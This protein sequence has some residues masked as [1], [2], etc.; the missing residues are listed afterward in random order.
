MTGGGPVENNQGLKV[1]RAIRRVCVWP[2]F[3]T[4][5]Y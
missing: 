2:K 5:V 3:D 1:E 4:V